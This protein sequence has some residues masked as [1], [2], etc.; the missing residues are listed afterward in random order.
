GGSPNEAALL[1][2][3]A[4]LR[5][6]QAEI[7]LRDHTDWLEQNK[8]K[9]GGYREDSKIL[10]VRQSLMMDD[11]ETLQAEKE[12]KYLPQVHEAMG[13]A[14]TYLNKPQTD[15]P[16]VAAETDAVNML[17]AEIMEMMKQG[18]SQ[19]AGGQMAMLMQMMG[20]GQGASPGGSMAGGTTD[21]ANAESAGNKKGGGSEQRNI[22]KAVGRDT[23]P[24][25]AEY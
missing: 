23:R 9:I 24:M 4:L 11:V 12:G 25:P 15:K 6:R 17:E 2:M 5:L 22:E 19:G 16:T 18:E 7:N 8:P 13:E 1:R 3:L 21:Q 14:E 10:S 20:M